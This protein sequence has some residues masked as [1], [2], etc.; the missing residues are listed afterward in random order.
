M[1]IIVGNS[2]VQ[3]L[4][5]HL[6][7]KSDFF[8]LS[9]TLGLGE[10]SCEVILCCRCTVSSRDSAWLNTDHINS[11]NSSGYADV[12]LISSLFFLRF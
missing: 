12:G 8:V 6:K 1:C 9:R 2:L 4:Y 3:V 10:I 5:S 11:G 7:I